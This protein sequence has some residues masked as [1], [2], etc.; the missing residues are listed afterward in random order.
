ML[1]SNADA[2]RNISEGGTSA[3]PVSGQRQK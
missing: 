2:N 1:Q 3:N